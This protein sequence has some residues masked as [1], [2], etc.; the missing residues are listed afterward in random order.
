MYYLL[1]TF[2]KLC[3]I[4]II[5]FFSPGYRTLPNMETQQQTLDSFVKSRKRPTNNDVCKKGLEEN[6][7]GINKLSRKLSFDDSE[8]QAV[9]KQKVS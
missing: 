4:I 2:L 5:S 8:Q 6:A 3:F 9:K 7:T 1:I